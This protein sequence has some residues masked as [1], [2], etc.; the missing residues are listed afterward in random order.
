MKRNTKL[1]CCAALALMLAGTAR[2]EEPWDMRAAMTYRDAQGHE[3][4]N[5]ALAACAQKVGRVYADGALRVEGIEASYDGNALAVVWTATN[6]TDE[7]LYLV[8]EQPRDGAVWDDGIGTWRGM[9]AFLQPGETLPGML[10]RTIYPSAG[11]DGDTMRVGIDFTALRIATPYRVLE[12]PG[13]ADRQA[14]YDRLTGEGHFVIMSDGE[15]GTW[16]LPE[17]Y[18]SDDLPAAMD[19]LYEGMGEWWLTSNCMVETGQ[20]AR[21]TMLPVAFSVKLSGDD[22]RWALGNW[23]TYVGAEPIPDTIEIRPRYV[24]DGGTV[25]MPDGIVLDARM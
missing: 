7:P 22:G 1:L 18:V 19:R 6:L 9:E 14:A 21:A 13:D 11:M 25:S 16:S 24:K 4:V 17:A 20:F 8:A 10:H 3:A 2:A 15:T 12:G 5:E 23:I